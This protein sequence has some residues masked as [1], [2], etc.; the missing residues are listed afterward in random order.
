MWQFSALVDGLPPESLTMTAIRTGQAKA[1]EEAR[2]SGQ[3][4][5]QSGE[6]DFDPADFPWSKSEM[7]LGDVIDELRVIRHIQLVKGSPKGHSVP[8]PKMVPR[9]GISRKG[10]D[11]PHASKMPSW[12]REVLLEQRRKNEES[13][14]EYRAQKKREAQKAQGQGG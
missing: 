4:P 12:Q 8:M 10:S 6:P 3:Q 2:E 11:R 9:P 13:W 7:L 5:E 1:A 14:V